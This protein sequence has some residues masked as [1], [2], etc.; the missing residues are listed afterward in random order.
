M[1]VD[2]V[3]STVIALTTDMLI[4]I[5]IKNRIQEINVNNTRLKSQA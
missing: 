5:L 3:L 4:R 1:H 2:D